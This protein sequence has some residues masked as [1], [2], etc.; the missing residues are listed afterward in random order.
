MNM[1]GTPAVGVTEVG[2]SKTVL[3][4]PALKEAIKPRSLGDQKLST[5]PLVSYLVIR[6]T[7]ITR[8]RKGT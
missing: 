1:T 6:N 7:D 8:I 4:S 5:H 3:C 2:S